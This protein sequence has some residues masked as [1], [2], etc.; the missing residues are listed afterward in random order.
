[1]LKLISGGERHLLDWMLRSIG[2]KLIVRLFTNDV[3]I[4]GTTVGS[5]FEEAQFVEYA[6]AY[7]ERS[8]WSDPVV[9][10]LGR[11]RVIYN[12]HKQYTFETSSIINGNYVVDEMNNAI[13][14]EKFTQPR[15]QAQNSRLIF[16]PSFTLGDFSGGAIIVPYEGLRKLTDWVF[17]SVG[18]HQ[19]FR[20]FQNNIFPNETTELGDFQEADFLGYSYRQLSRTNWSEPISTAS[21]VAKT[22]YNDLLTWF[23]ETQQALYGFYVTDNNDTSV[24][25]C[26]RFP[27]PIVVND[28]VELTQ[29]VIL[30]LRGKK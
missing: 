15:V 3:D 10:N 28:G 29:R 9:D 17:R 14:A 30:T 6:P 26:H 21:L 7:L 16:T 8:S 24:L 4:T 1:M 13:F 5:D 20:L 18:Q 2:T 23:P 22:E 11:A 27:E 12:T 19:K 25:W